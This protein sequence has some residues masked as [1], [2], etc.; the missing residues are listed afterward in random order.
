MYLFFFLLEGENEREKFVKRDLKLYCK[1][2]LHE[3]KKEIQMQQ[4]S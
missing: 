2:M 4:N 3:K 1:E